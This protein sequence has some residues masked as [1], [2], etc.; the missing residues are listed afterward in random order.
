MTILAELLSGLTERSEALASPRSHAGADPGASPNDVAHS[1]DRLA[2]AH[3]TPL[4]WRTSLED[5]LILAG[6]RADEE[7]AVAL[8]RELG[9][10]SELTSAR[11]RDHWTLARVL[12][13]LASRSGYRPGDVPPDYLLDDGGALAV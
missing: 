2:A 13:A 5:L 6:V 8:A 10:A 11:A 9:Y 3:P 4:Q 1:L 12:E 7:T